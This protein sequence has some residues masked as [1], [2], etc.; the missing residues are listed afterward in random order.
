MTSKF[1]HMRFRDNSAD[2]I[3]YDQLGDEKLLLEQHEAETADSKKVWRGRATITYALTLALLLISVVL[4][5]VVFSGLYKASSNHTV[6]IYG[7]E[8]T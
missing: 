4:N 8:S 3:Q 6:E 1:L 7:N 5:V 2:D